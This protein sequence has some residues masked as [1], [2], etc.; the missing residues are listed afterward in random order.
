[1]AIEVFGRYRFRKAS[2]DEIVRS[3][4]I[5]R[6]GLYLRSPT[7]RRCPG[8]GPAGIDVEIGDVD[9][10]CMT[11]RRAGATVCRAG[12]MAGAYVGSVLAS[13]IGTLLEK[14]AMELCD[15]VDPATLR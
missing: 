4:G 6:Q 12:R 7:R 1:M 5:F 9:A 2:M 11:R 8:R 10:A 14:P 13:D 15:I 3:A